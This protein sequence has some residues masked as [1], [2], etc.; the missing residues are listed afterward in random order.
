MDRVDRGLVKLKTAG[1]AQARLVAALIVVMFAVAGSADGARA[2]TLRPV[3]DAGAGQHGSKRGLT[4]AKVLRVGG[5]GRWR[6]Y[7]RFDGLPAGDMVARAVLRLTPRGPLPSALTVWVA[8]DR[9]TTERALVRKGIRSTRTVVARW[10]RPAAC[11]R[12][13]ARCRPI[14]ID[15]TAA[16]RPGRALA[17]VVGSRSR[18][19][20]RFASREAGLRGSPALLVEVAVATPAPAPAPVAAPA[21]PRGPSGAV[22]VAGL[23]TT[24]AELATRPTSGAP[25]AA[26][27]A[28]ADGAPGTAS[29]ADQNSDHDINTLAAA[30]VYARTK[31]AAY[32]AKAAAGIGAAIGTEQGGRTLA[33]GRNLASYAIAA[34]LIE[35]GNYD[36]A[37]DGRFRSWLSAV[38]TE[39]L[40]GDTLIATSE[41]RPNNWGT[42]AGASRVAAD[43]YLGDTADL[44]RAA[45]VF[46]GWLGDRSAYSGFKFGDM[47]W[48]VDPGRP[49][50]VQPAGA[51]KDG[52][53]IDGA[54][55]D[56]MRRGCALQTPPCPTDY[57]WEGLQGVV[58][59]A[60][61]LSRRGYDA[62]GWQ[63]SAVLRAVEFLRRL[64]QVYGGWW[65][66]ADDTWQP[67]IVN[68]AYGTSLP[69]Q[70][71]SSPGKI[72]A[73]T[74]WALG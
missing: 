42:M 52:L 47:S 29:I 34:D 66:S 60:R 5:R 35:L 71:P 41:Q 39:D 25:W 50:G 44:D 62:F 48:Q 37:L 33:L 46:R 2:D 61:L 31:V 17:L 10:K 4:T 38:R 55:A 51:T 21:P 22:P 43:A 67:W 65:A 14:S 13:P 68:S 24:A 69:E 57:A 74:D 49:V 8:R 53:D 64:D 58:V 11:R 20:A 16:A 63:S 23:W 19:V 9:S 26:V 72:M 56:D 28:A 59:E 15:V 6:S 12:R 40:G 32:R 7:V 30:L 27:K 54:L 70:S 73:W 36:A 18:R 1:G 3:A 45:T